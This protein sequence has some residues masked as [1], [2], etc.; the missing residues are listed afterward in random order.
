MKSS[1]LDTCY[2]CSDVEMSDTPKHR[3]PPRSFPQDHLAARLIYEAR[4]RTVTSQSELARRLNVPQQTI[5]RWETGATEPSFENVIRAIGACG[6][7]LLAAFVPQANLLD[8]DWRVRGVPAPLDVRPAAVELLPFDR[9]AADES[10]I[11]IRR[12][13]REAQTQRRRE[14]GAERFA[15]VRNH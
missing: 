9:L 14:R 10:K 2:I 5:S 12:S 15:P 8:R 3:I 6:W 13:F 7:D 1:L 11:N 4:E